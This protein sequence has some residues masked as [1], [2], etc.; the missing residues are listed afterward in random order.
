[1]VVFLVALPLCLGIAQASGAPLLSG[2]IAGIVGGLLVTAISSSQ[3]SVSG[4][5]AGSTAVVATGIGALGFRGFLLALVLAGVMQILLGVFR[6]G[7]I[8][9]FFPSPA[10]K[11]MLAAIGVLII[12]KQ[13][14]HTI[15]YDKNWEGSL[16]SGGARISEEVPALNAVTPAAV[17]V[18]L[19]CFGLYAV[20]SKVQKLPGLKFVPAAMGAV[21][22]G[23]LVV[24]AWPGAP[25]Q[26]EHMVA[27]PVFKSVGDIGAAIVSP[28]WGLLTDGKVWNTAITV[29]IVASIETLLCLEAVDRLDPERRIS[30]PN[31]EL[32]AQGAGNLVSGLLGGLPMTSVIVRSSVNVQAGARTRLSSIVH[33]FL[34]LVSVLFLASLFNRV[35]LASLAVVL[36][37]VGAK[38]TP[39]KLWRSMWRAGY[40]QFVPFAITV[41]AIVTTDLL[42]GTIVGLLVGLAFSI[43]RQQEN[44]IVK[45]EEGQ[46]VVI[47]FTKDM[48]FLQKAALKDTLRALPNGV[49][50][51]IDRAACDFI[52][53]DIEEILMEFSET[54]SLRDLT[55]QEVLSDEARARRGLLSS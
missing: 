13:L 51:T 43:R 2:L 8:A 30:P 20:W 5:T 10:I 1:M 17:V 14:P 18:T 6:L 23:A 45:V 33:G 9:H 11:G 46:Q 4:P 40:S 37:V 39:M 32:I 31:R 19:L 16:T 48:T 3:L 21:V 28:D 22:V 34:L 52:D 36:L 27:L 55:V 12:L 26:P 35:P 7:S 15:G 47:K 53:D 44:S 41:G 49:A 25:L 38:L 54:A 24:A 42:R 29:C 50:V